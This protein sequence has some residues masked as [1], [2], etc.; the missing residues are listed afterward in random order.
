MRATLHSNTLSLIS[1]TNGISK[2][3]RSTQQEKPASYLDIRPWLLRERLVLI[4]ENLLCRRHGGGGGSETLAV[5]D[6]CGIWAGGENGDVARG[7]MP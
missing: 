3:V 1:C 4:H 7:V 6:G 5:I 2:V